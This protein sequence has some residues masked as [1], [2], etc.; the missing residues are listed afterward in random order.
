[1]FDPGFPIAVAQ[2][3]FLTEP[4]NLFAALLVW[5][6]VG[7][8][9]VSLIHW[10]VTAEIDVLSGFAGICLAAAVG[11]LAVN[12]PHPSLAPVFVIVAI[13]TVLIAPVARLAMNR[14]ALQSIEVEAIERAYEMLGA[15]PDN[16]GAKI[17]LS[18]ALW[19][20]G[21]GSFAVAIAEGALAAAPVE[22]FGE[23]NRMLAQW[24]AAIRTNPGVTQIRCIDC[25]LV[26]EPGTMF[27]TRCGAPYLLD[28]AQGKWMQSGLLKRVTAGWIAAVGALVAIP[29]VAVAFP[30]VVSL[31]VVPLLV[32]VGAWMLYAA[33]REPKPSGT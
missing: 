22:V 23:E 18:R 21:I 15:K 6:P 28:Y 12:P 26:N 17:R 16:F 2:N 29:S 11:F 19:N 14:A 24:K 33:F 10:M 1:M 3:R 30:P 8:W 4:F 25:G 9:I 32:F 20:K 27:C 13:G 31:I 7:I 5:I